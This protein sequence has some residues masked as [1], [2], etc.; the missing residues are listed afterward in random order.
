MAQARRRHLK[1]TMARIAIVGCEASGKT[2]FMSALTDFYPNLVPENSASNRF[3]AFAHRQ[4]RTLRQWPPAT[5]PGR[6]IAL[7][8]SLRNSKGDTLADISMLEFGGE[9]FRA[10]FRED[11]GSSRRQA[12]VKE[13]MDYLAAADF[14]IILVSLKELLRD[15]VAVADAE[16][17]RSTEALWVTR[18]LIE[19][20]RE[21]LPGAGVV[22]GLTQAD[23]YRDALAAGGGPAAVFAARWPRIRAVAPGIPVVEIASVSATDADGRPAEGF[24]TDGIL[25][26]M[27]EFARQTYGD[28][29]KL[30]KELSALR[31]D[32][33]AYADGREAV[34]APIT[35][36]SAYS[37][38]V[39]RFSRL[40]ADVVRATAITGDDR[41]RDIGAL[42]AALARHEAEAK[43]RRAKKSSGGR[44]RKSRRRGRPVVRRVFLL[45]LL[46]ALTIAFANE[47]LPQ[48][49][50][51][52]SCMRVISKLAKF[53]KKDLPM[54]LPTPATNAA[55]VAAATNA[56]PAEAVNQTLPP[57]NP[58]NPVNPVK[59]PEPPSTNHD[60]PSTNHE[61][62]TANHEYRLWH[63]HKGGVIKAKWIDTA[64]D[65]KSITLETEKGRRIRA[66]LHKFSEADQDY[67]KSK[68]K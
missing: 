41:S 64:K 24:R 10:A 31:E 4:L 59:T 28:A 50:I 20:I 57:P 25:P 16:F 11:E 47:Y 26:A 37:S 5:N 29:D 51:S 49:Y 56:S 39:R 17:E 7:E 1:T 53:S 67:I 23:R 66:V 27:R 43:K 52:A 12:A 60:L 34:H 63:D 61:P 32:L 15:D 22:I 35:G 6:T 65:G 19:F 68:L 42:E 45:A 30:V 3:A 55:P 58:V 40:L 14:V 36:D 33:D 54:P 13:L 21:R 8:W 2:V 48:G 62:R 18:G 44:R 38:R 46:L 9:T